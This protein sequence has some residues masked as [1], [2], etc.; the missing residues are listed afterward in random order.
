MFFNIIEPYHNPNEGRVIIN[1]NFKQIEQT[2]TG[3]TIILKNGTLTNI[4]FSGN[5]KTTQI[6]FSTFFADNDYCISIDSENICRI[7][8]IENKTLSG[9]TI[10]S[11]SNKIFI[12]GSVFWIALKKL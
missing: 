1:N 7:W 11:N 12:E 10:N 2:L 6:L 9:F 8:T 5:P 4:D 3:S